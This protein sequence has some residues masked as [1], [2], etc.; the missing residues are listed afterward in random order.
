MS[1]ALLA[2]VFASS[3]GRIDQVLKD[4]SVKNVLSL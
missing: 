2:R 3:M 1:F 4:G